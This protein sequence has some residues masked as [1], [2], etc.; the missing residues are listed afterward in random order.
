VL[1]LTTYQRVTQPD[2]VGFNG[3]FKSHVTDKFRAWQIVTYQANNFTKLPTPSKEVII[4]WGKFSY[5]NIHPETI[6]KT[7]RSIGFVLPNGESYDDG[8]NHLDEDDSREDSTIVSQSIVL[9]DTIVHMNE[10]QLNT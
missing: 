10:M 7:F 1:K 5:N 8:T 6:R 9:N 2:D 3:L 4:E